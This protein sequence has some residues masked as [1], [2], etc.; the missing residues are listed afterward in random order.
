VGV[1]FWQIRDPGIEKR[2]KN[3]SLRRRDIPRSGEWTP[4]VS[5][6]RPDT[7]GDYRPVPSEWRREGAADR[8]EIQ[9]WATVWR[10]GAR[11]ERIV[12]CPYRTRKNRRI[13]MI[14]TAFV[15]FVAIFAIDWIFWKLKGIR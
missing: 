12:G 5:H 2:R 6:G 4:A 9:T 13:I 15:F 11:M 3:H 8:Y 10:Q 1:V 14:E 7:P